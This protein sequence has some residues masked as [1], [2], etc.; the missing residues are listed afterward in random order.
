M[1]QPIRL[2]TAGN[3]SIS[4]DALAQLLGFFRHKVHRGYRV[5]LLVECPGEPLNLLF[6][7]PPALVEF[8]RL[9]TTPTSCELKHHRS[10]HKNKASL[11]VLVH[12][13]ELSCEQLLQTMTDCVS[14]LEHHR[15]IEVSR[16][17]TLPSE[18]IDHTLEPTSQ[19]CTRPG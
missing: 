8:C 10:P 7:D 9:A 18:P 1:K 5:R 15:A 16:D 19:S 3:L 17:V 11:A 14:T 6:E 12:Q 4:E 13:L 2:D